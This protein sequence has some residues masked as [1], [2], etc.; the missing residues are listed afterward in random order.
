MLFIQSKR[1][2]GVSGESG[3]GSPNR[4]RRRSM[5][6]TDLCMQEYLRDKSRFADLFNGVFFSGREVV[7]P[8]ELS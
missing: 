5:G 7:R 2:Q 8:E 4:K 1:E 3:A 6:E